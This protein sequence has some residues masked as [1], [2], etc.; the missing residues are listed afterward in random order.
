MIIYIYLY[1]YHYYFT[2]LSPYIFHN[3]R[4]PCAPGPL[5]K[6]CWRQERRRGGA[7]P[8]AGRQ[9]QRGGRGE[10]GR[11]SAKILGKCGKI[12]KSM[13]KI[14]KHMEKCRKINGILENYGTTI[15]NILEFFCKMI[16][17]SMCNQC[18]KFGKS[19][20]R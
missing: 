16:W 10:D 11:K 2:L 8:V 1:I 5:P 4:A 3:I 12:R 6:L 9:G 20:K 15:Q 17:K 13:E 14:G 18:G 19:G 7:A